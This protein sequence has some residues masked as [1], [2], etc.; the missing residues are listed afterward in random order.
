MTPPEWQLRGAWLLSLAKGS[1]PWVVAS[2]RMLYGLLEKCSGTMAAT[3]GW[4]QAGTSWGMHTLHSVLQ[5]TLCK[6]SLLVEHSRNTQCLLTNY[7]L[8]GKG[9]GSPSHSE[10]P[11]MYINKFPLCN[12]FLRICLC[13]CG[14]DLSSPTCCSA[15]HPCPYR[16]WGNSLAPCLCTQLS[17]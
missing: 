8:L 9:S 3:W 16:P 12:S 15:Q 14:A 4:E 5:E 11:G 13:Y 2:A 6:Q 17:H 7:S 1:C 10:A